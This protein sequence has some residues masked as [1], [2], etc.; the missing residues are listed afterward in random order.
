MQIDLFIGY[1][2]E[3]TYFVQACETV[4]TPIIHR[5]NPRNLNLDLAT[6][7]FVDGKWPQTGK[8]WVRLAQKHVVESVVMSQ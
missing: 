4:H 7:V 6:T 1:N 8:A 3:N 5:L 2:A